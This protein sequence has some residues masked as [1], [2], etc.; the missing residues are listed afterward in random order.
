MKEQNIGQNTQGNREHKSSLFNLAFEKKEDKLALYNAI[1]NTNYD[2]VD[3]LEVDTLSNALYMG[4]KNDI[5]FLIGHTM[6]LYEHQSTKN[7]NMPIRGLI[8]L[9][10]QLENYI[11]KNK[12]NVYSTKMQKLPT[13]KYI[14]FY[15][16]KSNEPDERIMKLSDAFI[17]DGGCIECEARLLNINYGH[18]REL[19]E[20]CNRLR[21]YSI[22]VATVRKY[23]DKKEYDLTQAI[24]LAIQECLQEGILEDIL[25]TQRNEVMS[26]VLSTFDKELYEKDLKE[27]AFEEGYDQGYGQGLDTGAY[28]KLCSLI[29]KKLDKGLNEYEIADLLEE[30]ITTVKKIIKEIQSS[31]K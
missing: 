31:E 2:N 1:N 9:T 24:T 18:N 10:K 15:N 20:K 7:A 30:D 21:E 27:E 17:K 26:M 4:V 3:E 5:S 25:L 28:Q 14:V 22:F 23:A 16:G 12:L 8:Y 13:P 6:N 19:M 11:A 29:Y